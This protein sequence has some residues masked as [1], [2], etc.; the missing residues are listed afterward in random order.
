MS[1]RYYCLS[2]FGRVLSSWLALSRWLAPLMLVLAG[3]RAAVPVVTLVS[4]PRQ[5]LT[6]GSNV[7]LSVTV[8]GATSLQWQH[9]NQPVAGATVAT[10]TISGA[11]YIRDGGWYNMIAT[12]SDGATTGATIFVNVRPVKSQV[13]G[14]GGSAAGVVPTI[15]NAIKPAAG[16][17][18]ADVLLADGTVTSWGLRSGSA[19][20]ASTVDAENG[21]SEIFLKSDG[22]VQVIGSAVAQPPA[23]LGNIVAVASG[24]SHVVALR[25]D[26]T[27]VAWGQ[28]DYGATI[29]PANLTHVV[30]VAAGDQFSYALKSDGTVVAWGRNDAGQCT[31]PAGLANVVAIT[32]V[33]ESG[34]VAVRADGSVAGWPST[35]NGTAIPAGISS[36]VA[37]SGGY[38]FC[39]AIKSDGTVTG[40]GVNLTGSVFSFPPG[41]NNAVAISSTSVYN[42]YTLAVREAAGDIVPTIV[43]SPATTSAFTNQDVTLGVTTQAGTAVLG[44]QWRKGG[45]PISGATNSTLFLPR[46]TTADAGS[47][48]VIVSDWLGS[49]TSAAATLSV[50][51]SP[52]V[53]LNATGRKT[54]S[55]GQNFTFTSSTQLAGNVTYQW[56]KNGRPIAGATNSSLTMS[57]PSWQD[58]GAYQ[59][60]ATN[61]AGPFLTKAVFLQVTPS[62]TQI[63][64]TSGAAT[65]LPGTTTHAIGVAAGANHFLALLADGTVTGW[66][67]DTYGE[68]TAFAGFSDIVAIA[69]GYNFSMA[70]HADGTVS[71]AG[72]VNFTPAG[73]GNVIAIS[74]G[75]GAAMALKDDGSVVAWNTSG[76]DTSGPAIN[77]AVAVAAGDQF[78]LA[79]HADGTVSQWGDN[80]VAL[81]AGLTGVTSVA[82][83]VQGGLALKQDGSLVYW[84]YGAGFP[85]GT[86]GIV[87]ISSLAYSTCGLKTDGSVLVGGYIGPSFTLTDVSPVLAMS[88]GIGDTLILRDASADAAPV[89]TSQP[90]NRT[91][92][93]SGNTTFAVA[94]TGSPAPAFLWQ[95]QPAGTSGFGNITSSSPFA[96][97]TTAS[98]S[99]SPTD[100]SMNGDQ[101]RCVVTNTLGQAVSNT[102]TLTVTTAPLFTSAVTTTFTAGSA[103]SFTFAATGSPAPTFSVTAGTFPTWAI[104]NSATGVISGT[105]PAGAASSYTFAITA[106]NTGGSATQTFTLYV[107]TA[108]HLTN[109]SS[110]ITVPAQGNVTESFTITGGTKTV[111]LRAIGP[112]LTQFGITGVLADPQIVVSDAGSGLTIAANDDWGGSTQLSGAFNVVGAFP[113][114]SSTSKDAALLTS[115]SPGTYTVTMSGTGGSS[116]T[117]ILE[118]Y[119]YPDSS[120]GRFSYLA[121]RA[122][123]QIIAGF[124]LGG[125]TTDTLLLRA[126]GPSLNQAGTAPDPKL[127]L[128]NTSGVTLASND[129]WGGDTTFAN[130]FAILGASPFGATSLDSALV[131]T[132]SPGNYTAQVSSSTGT[133]LGTALFEVFD[134]NSPAT[135]LKP[136]FVTS[137]T[138]QVAVQG[139]S[140]ALS[141]LAAGAPSF[142]YQ[143]FK[144]GTAITGATQSTLTLGGI[145]FTDA[146]SYTVT[147]TGSSGVATSSAGVL[148][149]TSA[150]LPTV[151]IGVTPSNNVQVGQTVTWSSTVSGTAPFAY[152]WRKDGNNLAGATS[153]QL[154]LS[155]VQAAQ[156]GSYDLVVTNAAG[157]G[158]SVPIVLAVA[159]PPPP[160]I[161]QQPVSN[162]I[163]I[164]GVEV[165]S[166]VLSNTTG[167][168]YQWRKNGVPITGNNTNATGS[169]YVF[170]TST[171]SDSAV[172]DVV[173]SNASGNVTSAPATLSFGQTPLFS[174]P[175]NQY[176]RPGEPVSMSILPASTM[177]WL[178]N[179]T[180][181]TGATSST[182]TISTVATTDLGNYT[183]TASDLARGPAKV[184]LRGTGTLGRQFV[185][186]GASGAIAISSDGLS[187]A[188]QI[189][190]TTEDLRGVAASGDIVVAVGANGSILSS[191]NLTTW[192]PV[193]VPLPAPTTPLNAVVAG[194]DRFVAAGNNGR[195]LVN[196]LGSGW[197]LTDAMTLTN[198]NGLAYGAG[199]YVAVGNKGAIFTSPDGFT[200]TNRNSQTLSDVTSITY[201]GSQFWAVSSASELLTSPDG[202]NWAAAAIP[203]PATYHSLASDGQKLVAVGDG[204]KIA[205]STDGNT[206]TLR[207]AGPGPALYGVTWSGVELPSLGNPASYLSDL[208]FRIITQPVS[209]SVSPGNTVS[210]GVTNSSGSATYQ[211]SKDGA[212]L[213]GATLSTLTLSNVQTAQAGAY[214]VAVTTPLGTILSAPAKLGILGFGSLANQFFAVGDGGTILA[215]TDG[216]NFVSRAGGSSATFRA[217]TAS[218]LKAVAVGR[219]GVLATSAD[220]VTWSAQNIVGAGN[221]RG[222]AAGPVQYVAV[223]PAGAHFVSL[224]QGA[225]WQSVPSGVNQPMWSVAWNGQRFLAVGESGAVSVSADGLA[226]TAAASPT[227]ERLYSVVAN[228]TAF[229]AV[230]E[231]GH[232]FATSDNG[233]TWQS[234]TA[235][236]ALWV[237]G[238]AF[239]PAG[240]RVLV[241]DS[242]QIAGSTDGVHWFARTS[243]TA[244]RLYGVTWSGLPGTLNDNIDQVVN[245]PALGIVTA[246]VATTVNVG[247]TATFS[248][249]A[250]GVAPLTY[251]WL[252]NGAQV[253]GAVNDTLLLANAQSADAGSYSVLVSNDTGTVLSPAA[254]LT[255]VPAG[256]GTAPTITTQPAS[257]TATVGGSVSFSVVAQGSFPLS[258]QWKFNGLPISGAVT[259]T[260]SL[261]NVQLANSG[262]YT[263]VVSNNFGAVTSAGAS[264]AVSTATGAPT[265]T[266]QP[267]G[268]SVTAG[269]DVAFS[270]VASGNAFLSYQWYLNG[271]A[272]S[273][274]A[275]ATLTLRSVT[276]AQAGTYTVVVSNSLGSATSD[277]ASLNVVPAGMTATHAQVGSGYVPGSTVTITNTLSY[278][279]TAE[280]LAWQVLLPSGWSFTS[281]A[282]SQGD[283]APLAGDTGVL[284]WAWSTPP[285]SPVTFTYTLHVPS[286]FTGTA[287]FA[288]LAIVREGGVPIQFM[289]RPDPLLIAQNTAVHSADTNGD[290]QISLLELTRVIELFNTRNSTTRTGAYAVQDGTEDGY[291]SDTSRTAS[292]TVTLTRYHTADENHDGKID[293]LELTRVIE[294]FNYRNGSTR[295]G[296]YHP[297][298]GTEDGFAPGP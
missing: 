26:G 137:P 77:D 96:G 162:R 64:T 209:T 219:N 103:G 104:L 227:T 75:E 231:A 150:T 260:L 198:F 217:V 181:I 236:G 120:A 18:I 185:A 215:S 106:T 124:V 182:Y 274:G 145:Q 85:D 53:T 117:A 270:V 56:R 126:N 247:S 37:V 27:V 143:W 161:T 228:G 148:S 32:A 293:L 220:G 10:Y 280:T 221:L 196:P 275:S 216:V 170:R 24:A 86:T 109:L 199:T 178:K 208:N 2:P 175:L 159:V 267:V 157:T 127:T 269:S 101:F 213:S 118:I 70:L 210:F 223:G 8:T 256:S 38:D 288:S 156:A 262:S 40:W 173:I 43:T 129:N 163:S 7:T 82:A 263:V 188:T 66:G 234:H 54:I 169:T 211:W 155:N 265:I 13:V 229:L 130:L 205:T 98:L 224:D 151:A 167:A 5:V 49:A 146:A 65:G 35:G 84:G 166:V 121:V 184:A 78:Y 259:S 93:A 133:S 42:R 105:P 140:V 62:S 212:P 16:Q 149:V 235:S 6:V 136:Y 48:D 92:L 112:S 286:T 297:Q 114:V 30:A 147:A 255:V 123:V 46:V 1:F 45:S 281:G 193:P 257:R 58:A 187:W 240:Q 34:G 125:G 89:I 100:P 81:P 225:T 72:I 254:T 273:G 233:A 76:L 204:G 241:G 276:T 237:R 61:A 55:V 107:V 20:V 158:T 9:N 264:L 190:G 83:R 63:R 128:L 79:L 131:T 102:A 171:L 290:G 94:A 67:D 283:I 230:T 122:P 278:T 132:L 11:Q 285:A 154:V 164:G 242:G 15:T 23:G 287:S 268:Q 115:L 177:Q 226:W 289:A 201:T 99:V 246:P 3:V 239:S 29:V 197:Y 258:Y 186:V 153:N 249:I 138:S 238:L 134:V 180:A 91:V 202:A 294:L 266:T 165:L 33:Q 168:S 152:Q 74:A 44:Y 176:V 21:Y 243:P 191:S 60:L 172:Y 295:T 41:M 90:G 87:T 19:G 200:W 261:T 119:E 39:S 271:V 71:T 28:V 244:E 282:G 292:A 57:S 214:T 250:S 207:V 232:V 12:N 59:L 80:V 139:T 69:A 183:V 174:N 47:Y 108:G 222:V 291:A 4:D 116:G 50:S 51:T 142:N 160:V 68:A 31:V 194:P 73:L 192:A 206:W 245:T 111:L 296:Q 36:V 141:A 144:N 284:S 22:T 135:D 110:R 113:L 252:H 17:N 279:G 195:L 14:W 218:A 248:V 203:L 25:S 253:S 95:R 97:S 277:P 189:S 88:A 251:Q 179:G 52:A 272:V 298:S